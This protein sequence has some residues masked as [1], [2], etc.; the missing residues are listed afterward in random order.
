MSVP[1]S[2]ASDEA[3][4]KDFHICLYEQPDQDTVRVYIVD[5]QVVNTAVL[6][7]RLPG[8]VVVH[9]GLVFERHEVERVTATADEWRD[10]L[11]KV[12]KR[13]FDTSFAVAI[14]RRIRRP[15][16]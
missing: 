14:L 6:Q 1:N 9:H 11:A 13:A 3:D 8:D 15:D 10:Y 5:F 12:G 4:S 7:G 2:L 16:S